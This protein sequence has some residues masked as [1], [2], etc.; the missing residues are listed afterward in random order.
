PTGLGGALANIAIAFLGR[1]AVNLNYTAGTDAVK[2]A[3]RQAGIRVVVT[4][5]RFLARVPLDLPAD[6]QRIYLEDVLESVTKGQRIRTFLLALLL[7]GWFIE[8][9]L[10]GLHRH[11]PDDILTIVFSSGSTGE[12]KGVL[13]THRNVGSN[14]DSAVRTIEIRRDDVLFGILP[15]FHS[16]GYTVCLWAPL[17]AAATVVYYPDPRAAKEVGELAR[18]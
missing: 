13:L 4:A 3:V 7:P 6:I 11:Q 9:F 10:L 8:R 2:S 15:F 17:V 14:V 18:R 1:T 16:F 12:P 5:K